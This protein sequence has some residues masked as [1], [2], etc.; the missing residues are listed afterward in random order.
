M[1]TFML[2]FRN[3]MNSSMQPKDPNRVP[4]WDFYIL[5]IKGEEVKVGPF[6]TRERLINELLYLFDVF[7]KETSSKY[8]EKL[9]QKAVEHRIGFKEY[10]G[11]LVD[12]QICLRRR[13]DCWSSGIG[14]DIHALA[15]KLDGIV[16]K[17]PK[18][19]KKVYQSFAKKVT[20]SK[21]NRMGKCGACGGSRVMDPNSN[22][23]GRAGI[24]NRMFNGN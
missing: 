18:I 8:T 15:G 16:D 22:N 14:D 3:I 19:V 1:V 10:I 9:R 17:A 20:P 7:D 21:V 12:H 5:N 2:Y 6:P 13:L 23:L 4:D 24:L 11:K